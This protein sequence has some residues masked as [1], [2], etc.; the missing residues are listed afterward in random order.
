MCLG[1]QESHTLGVQAGWK[2]VEQHIFRK[3]EK[4]MKN[5]TKTALIIV[6]VLVILGSLLCAV[7]LGI[8]FRFSEFWD[9]VETG[10]FS[11]GPIHH[12]P[13]FSYNY[14][15]Y[16]WADPGDDWDAADEEVSYFPW[17]D[18]KK[19]KLDVDYSSVI[20][21]EA[22]WEDREVRITVQY[23][24]E[25]HRHR[26]QSGINSGNTLEIENEG[27]GRIRNSDSSRVTLELPRKLM[28]QGQL[29]E[30]DLKQGKGCIYSEM[31][32][33]AEKISISVGAGQCEI[34]EKLTAEKELS[35]SVDAGEIILAE[36][37]A[38][39]LNLNGGVGTLTAELI[40]AQEIEIEGG[41]G[42]IEV[43]AAGK[44][45]DYSYD[46]ECGVGRLEIG[47]NEY[48]GLSSSRSIENPGGRKMKI[49]CGVGD[50]EVSFQEL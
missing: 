1:V 48:S 11:I 35:V 26:V 14:S 18:I 42:S 20:I 50:V 3:G 31:P 32:L 25:D 27:S 40:Q 12:I 44:E 7:G 46:I 10:E 49:E 33:T 28:E 9:Q 38:E 41:V 6:L 13:F 5:F 43:E 30:I 39:K 19:I 17:E 4:S 29:E 15:D 23:R 34:E 2:P 37:E 47:E 22:P 24:R 36:L 45:S 21:T 16:D 8:G